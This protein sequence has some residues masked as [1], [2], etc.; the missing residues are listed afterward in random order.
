MK[1]VAS[2]LTTLGI[3]IS[4]NAFAASPQATPWQVSIPLLQKG[5]FFGLEGIYAETSVNN[6][7]N[8]YAIYNSQNQPQTSTIEN[9]GNHWDFGYGLTLGYNFPNSGNDIDLTY[10]HLGN[11]NSAL[12]SGGGTINPANFPVNFIVNLVS[13]STDSTTAISNASANENFD[14]NQLDLT[15][16][17]QINVGSHLQLH[18]TIGLRYGYVKNELKANYN[19][20]EII[21]NIYS[22]EK[23]FTLPFTINTNNYSRFT[24]IGPE[25]GLDSNYSLGKGFGLVAHADSALL[26][27]QVYSSINGNISWPEVSDNNLPSFNSNFNYNTSSSRIVPITNLKLGVD[28]TFASNSIDNVVLE[29]GYQVTDYYNAIDKITGS[30]T[31]YVTNYNNSSSF[32]TNAYTKTTGD[33]AFQGVYASVK[34]QLE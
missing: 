26:V 11:S 9:L 6:G 24:G 22:P 23:D 34:L 25:L 32:T 10:S 20:Q 8:D 29:F 16:G 14:F 31:A 17:Q 33:F 15:A 21:D 2:T 4:Y 13:Q 3:I 7:L 1:K 18:P 27:G 30:G 5:L 12:T 28:Y 19:G